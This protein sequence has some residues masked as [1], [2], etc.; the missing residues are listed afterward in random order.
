MEKCGGTCDQD[1]RLTGCPPPTV[2]P[3][4]L[5]SWWT[6]LQDTTDQA[7]TLI[8]RGWSCGEVELTNPYAAERSEEEIMNTPHICVCTHQQI[9]THS[10]THLPQELCSGGSYFNDAASQPLALHHR[11]HRGQT[12]SLHQPARH[13]CRCRTLPWWYNDSQAIVTAT[14]HGPTP[15]IYHEAD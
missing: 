15:G 11:G 9:H 5:G 10:N 1:S 6:Q 12:V 2:L 4:E 7:L 8:Q 3:E 13:P 14:T